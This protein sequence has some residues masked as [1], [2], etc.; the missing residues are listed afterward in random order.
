MSCFP[1]PL[2][3]PFFRGF[4][5]NYWN[6]SSCR[7]RIHS[8][9]FGLAFYVRGSIL[10]Y[11]FLWS[12]SLCVDVGIYRK[13]RMFWVIVVSFVGDLW[14]GISFCFLRGIVLTSFLLDL[15]RLVVSVDLPE[16]NDSFLRWYFRCLRHRQIWTFWVWFTI[17]KV[18]VVFLWFCIFDTRVEV[19]N[20][21]CDVIGYFV[22]DRIWFVWDGYFSWCWYYSV[23]KVV[24]FMS[25]IVCF[26]GLFRLLIFKLC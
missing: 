1:Q 2:R 8:C 26:W 11:C 15:R 25:V 10:F 13:F 24:R 16:C 17:R 21:V 5:R 20:I 7:Y 9:T 19:G 4:I 12:F 22:L 3:F 18:L 23:W 6:S 14:G